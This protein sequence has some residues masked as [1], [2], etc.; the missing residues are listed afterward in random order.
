MGV[1]PPARWSRPDLIDRSGVLALFL[2]ADPTEGRMVKSMTPMR[3][4]F[5]A[6]RRSELDRDRG[7]RRLALAID[8]QRHLDTRRAASART[9]AHPPGSSD[10]RFAYLTLTHD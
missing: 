10:P 7:Y 2:R 9:E 3:Q 5:T 8:T 6:R 4:D 1:T